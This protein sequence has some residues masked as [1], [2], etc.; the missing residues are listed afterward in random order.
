[1]G[2]RRGV[3]GVL[4]GKLEG[5]GPLGRPTQRWEDKIK[6]IFR[7]RDGQA[8]TGLIWLKIGT[9]SSPLSMQ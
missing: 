7:N 5:K 2:E 6:L 4:I 8:W 9:G 3:Y 1:M